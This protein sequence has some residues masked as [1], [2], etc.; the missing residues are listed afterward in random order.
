MCPT[1]PPP[2]PTSE[3]SDLF[4]YRNN[5]ILETTM[6][7]QSFQTGVQQIFCKVCSKLKMKEDLEEGKGKAD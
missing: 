2:P 1:P 5:N 6:E 4:L 7:V 3:L